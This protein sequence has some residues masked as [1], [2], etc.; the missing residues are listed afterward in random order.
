MGVAEEDA[1]VASQINNH[2]FPIKI[3][4]VVDMVLVTNVAV[5]DTLQLGGGWRLVNDGGL[6]IK[7]TGG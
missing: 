2:I 1:T 5:E 6:G 4:S 3:I 7:Y